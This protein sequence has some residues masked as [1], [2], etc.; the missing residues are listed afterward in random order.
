MNKTSGVCAITTSFYDAIFVNGRATFSQLWIPNA[1]GSFVRTE[2]NNVDV[3]GNVLI[4]SSCDFYFYVLG[5]ELYSS[6]FTWAVEAVAM[7][8][9]DLYGSLA[10]GDPSAQVSCVKT[11]AITPVAVSGG[12]T[13]QAIKF[14]WFP[15]RDGR[16]LHHRLAITIAK[17]GSEAETIDSIVYGLLVGVTN[18]VNERENVVYHTLEQFSAG[19]DYQTAGLMSGDWTLDAGI[20]YE[21]TRKSVFPNLVQGFLHLDWSL[22]NATANSNTSCSLGAGGVARFWALEPLPEARLGSLVFTV[23]S[24][25]VMAGLGYNNTANAID[26]LVSGSFGPGTHRLQATTNTT[27]NCL[28]VQFFSAS[29][30]SVSNVS[31]QAVPDAQYVAPDGSR[32][33]HGD[34]WNGLRIYGSG[35]A[36]KRLMRI[37]DQPMDVSRSLAVAVWLRQLDNS[38]Y[39]NTFR[40]VYRVGGADIY[41]RPMSLW[42]DWNERYPNN[43][44]RFN[45]WGDGQG[46]RINALAHTVRQSVLRPQ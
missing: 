31:W 9:F 40:F 1:A 12:R 22:T 37:F 33:S 45:Y 32:L 44:Q 29:S 16:T 7:T 4:S 2:T 19:W 25:T 21:M 20:N 38:E 43:P 3:E 10:P 13:I 34:W 14:L 26:T 6:N 18:A 24:G 28:F 30:A 17:A 41:S 11:S 36:G 42:L 15:S 27:A 35:L 5:T 39:V 46:N 8:A 23:V